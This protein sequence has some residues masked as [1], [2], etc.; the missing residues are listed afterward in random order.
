MAQALKEYAYYDNDEYICSGTKPELNARTGMSIKYI[1]SVIQETK[2]R[3]SQSG[4][5]IFP[6]TD[7]RDYVDA[8]LNAISY[9]MQKENIT[10]SMLSEWIG[11]KPK[12]L[13]NILN[14][15]AKFTEIEIKK[16]EEIFQL[17]EGALIKHG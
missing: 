16:I 17:D 13:S 14:D 10:Q 15:R 8:K 1:H 12:T 2:R 4:K 3:G 6:L 9:L 11:L 7:E 5:K